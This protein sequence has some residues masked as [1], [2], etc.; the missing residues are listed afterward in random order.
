MRHREKSLQLL[1]MVMEHKYGV[2]SHKQ[3]ATGLKFWVV[4]YLR[5]DCM[6]L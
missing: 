2:S 4:A 3:L 6:K 5:F 1:Y